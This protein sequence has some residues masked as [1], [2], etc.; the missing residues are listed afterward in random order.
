MYIKKVKTGY[1]YIEKYIDE[2]GTEKRVKITLKDKKRATQVS[3][4][5][6]LDKKIYDKLNSNTISKNVK[7]SVVY[8]KWLQ[9]VAKTYLFSTYKSYMSSVRGFVNIYK[10][11]KIDRIKTTHLQDYL[12]R[13]SLKPKTIKN[14]QTVLGNLFSFAV[15]MQYIEENPV[16][17]VVIPRMKKTVLDY[18]I[19]ENKGLSIDE[20]RQVIAYCNKTNRSKRLTLIMEFLFLTGLRL[21]ELAGLQK[22]SVDLDH[23][24]IEIRHVTY[25]KATRENTRKLYPPKTRASFRKVYLNPRAI[26]IIEW[27]LENSLDKSFVFTNEKGNVVVQQNMYI[28]IR[29]VCE[30]ALGKFEN[31]KYNVHMLRHSHITI[32]AELGVPIKAIMER[33]GHSDIKTTL[34]VY[35]HVSNQMRKETMNKLDSLVLEP[36]KSTPKS[37]PNE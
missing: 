2:S 16:S 4:L 31:R 12:I 15:K 22:S 28:F 3:A 21:E 23:K 34:E 1:Q 37:T 30:N 26:E 14:R 35:S 20:L 24:Q 5:Q 10:D 17:S 29:N 36:K 13:N 7:L 9:M 6:L 11:W 32:L 25:S 18:E 19:Q 8:E 33:V 27:F